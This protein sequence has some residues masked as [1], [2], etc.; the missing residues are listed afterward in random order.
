MTQLLELR[1][2]QSQ[3]L[4]GEERR[5]LRGLEA[6]PRTGQRGEILLH[7]GE[8]ARHTV[9]LHSGWAMLYRDLTDGRRQIMYFCLPGDLVDPCSLLLGR[10][11]FSVAAITELRYSRVTLE[12]LVSIVGVQPRLALPLLSND[13]RDLLLL[14]AH[15]LSVGRMSA[16]ERIAALL[17]EL[18][19]RLLRV[20]A[21]RD[22]QLRLEASQ[23]ML[24][25]ATGLSAIHVN[26]VLRRMEREGLVRREARH[27]LVIDHQKLRALVPDFISPSPGFQAGVRQSGSAGE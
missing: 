14:R 21:A 12:Q 11:D 24:A 17:L 13:A 10:R 26:R 23:Q 25:D 8:V 9:L 2:D 15:L 20:D 4:T 5:A 1:L 6:H 7:A 27:L 18:W 16:R 22:G 19:E 3:P